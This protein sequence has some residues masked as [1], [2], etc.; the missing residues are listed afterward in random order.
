MNKKYIVAAAF[1]AALLVPSA[2]V[3]AHAVVKP[4]QAGIAAFQV[5]TLGVPSEKPI[6]TTSVRLVLPDGLNFVTP[7]VKPGWKVE[8]KT[9]STGKQVKDDDGNMID[10]QKPVEIDWTGGSIP[11]GQRDEFLFQAQVPSQATTLDWK[12]YQTYA[13]GSVLS[14]DQDPKTPQPKDASG[15]SDFSKVGPYS[16]T[17]VV[18]DLT[19]TPS[20]TGTA[21]TN[22]SSKRDT[23][24]TLALALSIVA[25]VFSVLALRKR[26]A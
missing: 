2:F 8:V 1:A 18:N 6:A 15:N 4:N 11:A 9:Q 14:W 24:T 17:M 16:E 3:S 12:V 5:F 26:S 25:V 23:T 19:P 10:E 21:D 22:S 20:A 13:D 7:N